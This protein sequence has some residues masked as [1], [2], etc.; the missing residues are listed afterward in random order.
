MVIYSDKTLDEFENRV[1]HELLHLLRLDHPKFIELKPKVKDACA[2]ADP[3][4]YP[5]GL[6][7]SM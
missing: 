7:F 2:I 5:L 4:E 6:F 1:A 3:A